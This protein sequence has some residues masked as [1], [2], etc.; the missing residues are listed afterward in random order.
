MKSAAFLVVTSLLFAAC[1]REQ[2]VSA[3]SKAG[4]TYNEVYRDD[5]IR[6]WQARVATT[7]RCAEFKE[8]FGTV[9]QRYDDA[10]NGAFVTD[11]TKVWEE[12]KAAGCA[13]PV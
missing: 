12:T 1:S 10:A 7:P 8:K 13:A 6:N 4:K 5:V 3:V 11:M 9:G 2:T